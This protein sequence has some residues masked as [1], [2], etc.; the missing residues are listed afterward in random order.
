[1]RERYSFDQQN[2][3]A[4][5]FQ[6]GNAPPVML[7]QHHP[8]ADQNSITL[9]EATCAFQDRYA[10]DLVKITPASSFQLRDLGQ[11]DFWNGDDLGRREFGPNLIVNVDDWHRLADSAP[12]ADHID[13]H[14]QAA[15]IIRSRV[16]KEIPVIQ[17]VFD[18]LFQARTLAGEN[19]AAQLE[20][21]PD[22]VARGLAFL[23]ARTCHLVER[24]VEAGVNG[25]F[26]AVQHAGQEPDPCRTYKRMGLPQSLQCLKA[27]GSNS[28]NF[29]HLHGADIPA[30]LLDAYPDTHI[31]FSFEESPLL[32][33]GRVAAPGTLL[34]GGMTP[35]RLVKQSSQMIY[36][37]TRRL[38]RRMAGRA[39]VLAPGCALYQATP[40]ANLTAFMSAARKQDL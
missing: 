16:S 27:A 39:F 13:E 12:K 3:F 14:L 18:P 36:E 28:L 24:F 37:E 30:E 1:M 34:S 17:T 23:T 15:Q 5:I 20:Q 6:T 10:C 9:V 2:E 40:S 19:W 8:E 11:T 33:E 21:D 38:V 29:V 22:A 32:Q 7:W 35:E 25:V 31:H 4:H 26:V